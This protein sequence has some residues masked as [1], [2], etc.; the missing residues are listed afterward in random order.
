MTPSVTFSMDQVSDVS[1]ENA[2]SGDIIVTEGDGPGASGSIACDDAGFLAAAR[3]RPNEDTRQLR[4]TL[5]RQRIGRGRRVD[6]ALEVPAGVN[7]EIEAG[8]ADIAIGVIAGRAR[9]ASGSGDITIIG[10]S[11]LNCSTGSG[12]IRV[13]TLTGAEARLSSGSGDIDVEDCEV[14]VQAK[15]GSGDVTIRSLSANLRAS[16]GSGDIHVPSTTGSVDLRSAS[17]SLSVGVADGL[18]AWLDLSTVSGEV[19]ITLPPSHEPA[20][21]ELYVSVTGRTASG[22]ISVFKV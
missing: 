12:D 14:A 21:D 19:T 4:I 22:D 15:S 7:L 1:I 10:A 13:R 17:G 2:G 20:V 3:V 11:E 5:P 18:P 9:L 16:S 8:S 6:I